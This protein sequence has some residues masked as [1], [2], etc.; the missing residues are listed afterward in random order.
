M[1]INFSMFIMAWLARV[2][3]KWARMKAFE[4]FYENLRLIFRP[5]HNGKIDLICLIYQRQE[6]FKCEWLPWDQPRMG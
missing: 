1:L 2:V 4:I 6:K 5:T 3:V